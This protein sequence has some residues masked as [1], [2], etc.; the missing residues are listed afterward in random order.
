MRVR[1]IGLSILLL[2][3]I[4]IAAQDDLYSLPGANERVYTSGSM[5]FS[6]DGRVLAAVNMLN[7]SVSVVT[8]NNREVQAE[9]AVGRFPNSL[10]FTPDGTR[11]LVVNRVDGTLAVI[12]MADYSV[13]AVYPVG[14]LPYAV[15]TND[16]N[17]AYISSQGTD[18]II[19][20]DINRG[21]LLERIATPD[22][23]VGMA[24]WG[25]F[26]Y[27]SHLW[28]GEVSLIHLPQKAVVHSSDTG[29]DVSFSPSLLIDASNGLAYLPQSH[30]NIQNTTPT[31]DTRIFPVINVLDLG[32][33]TVQPQ[34][35]ISLDI[36]D[37]PV[38]MPFAVDIDTYRKWLYVV[39]AGSNDLSII[40]LNS[41]LALAHIDVGPNPRSIRLNWDNTFLYVHNALGSSISVVD[42]R[43]LSVI[44]EIPISTWDGPL[45]HLIGARLFYTSADSRMSQDNWLS[46]ASC[47]FD[48]QSDGRVWSG[49]S[50]DSRNTPLLFGDTSATIDMNQHL[51]TLQ[52]GEGFPAD[53]LDMDMLL[54]YLQSIDTPLAPT[55]FDE[56]LI[57]QGEVLFTELGCDSCHS[58]TGLTDG[59]AHDVGTGGVFNTPSLNWL[60][61]SAPY[62]HDGTAETLYDVFVMPGT[63]QIITL[64]SPENTDALIAYLFNLP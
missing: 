23:P 49:F 25:D 22:S 2:F 41:R 53:S 48:G 52:A 46:C 59:L 36:A 30:S 58:S 32:N 61:L 13:I 57:A 14:A 33:M 4:S 10:S 28:S 26:L 50:G 40:D 51:R 55:P 29:S 15:V 47:H 9:I 11:L 20:I 19:H 56:S 44:D 34:S 35:R 7:D 42:T 43:R 21:Q 38:N 17:S 6:S 8:L 12:S 24:L 37:R 62:F 45:D 3:T 63:H 1:Y 64:T 16:D 27:V 54:T 60:W 31:F 18:E 5:V 39:N